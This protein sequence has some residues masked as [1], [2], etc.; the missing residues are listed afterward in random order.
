MDEDF[1]IY[2]SMQLN[3]IILIDDV[4]ECLSDHYDL[5]D[6]MV[7]F[8]YSKCLEMEHYESAMVMKE[9]YEKEHG[10]DTFFKF[11]KYANT[12]RI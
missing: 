8:T 9:L 5:D 1:A 11:N 10:K 3:P 7:A 4:L 6:S 2:E 12:R